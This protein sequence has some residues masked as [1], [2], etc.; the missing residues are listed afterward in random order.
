MTLFRAGDVPALPLELVPVRDGDRVDLTPYST[1]QAALL[2]PAGTVT[3]PDA[4]LLADRVDV[5]LPEL[6]LE[7]LW[8]VS[9]QLSGT[10]VQDTF[11][12][13][14]FVVDAP[15]SGWHTLSTAR[16]EWKDAPP[17]DVQLYQLLATA[18]ADVLAFAPPLASYAAVPLTYRLGQLMQARNR[19]NASRVN[20]QGGTSD[21]DSFSL[22]PFPLDWAIRQLLRPAQGRK[23]VF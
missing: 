2:D 17:S 23:R 15:L 4:Q 19:A 7:G 21:S 1:A 6:E 5:T 9:L 18:K 3:H 8:Q 13:G 22:T 12:G 14:T 10:D 11:D 16:D 20:P